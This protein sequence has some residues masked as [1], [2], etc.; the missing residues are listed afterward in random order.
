MQVGALFKHWSLRLLTPDRVLQKTY[1]AFKT[2]LAW[3]GR[4]HALMAEFE[5]LYH[6]GGREDCARTRCRQRQLT[7]AVL[8]MVDALELM[9]PGMA[10][11]L[12]AYVDKFDF[13]LRLQLAPPERFLIPPFVVDHAE[14]VDPILV[15]NKSARLV[16]LHQD[17]GVRIPDGFTITTTTFDLLLAHNNVRP[18]MDLLLAAIDLV[19]EPGLERISQALTTMVL[20]LEIPSQVEEEILAAYDGLAERMGGNPVV[21]VRSS[22]QQEDGAFSF[23]GQY[24]SALGVDRAHVLG[25][26]RQVLAS[27]Y[28]PQALRYRLHAGLCDEEAA[29]AVLVLAMVDAVASG[30]V[31]TQDPVADEEPPLLVHSVNGLGLPLVGG[32]VEPDVFVFPAGSLDPAVIRQGAQDRQLVLRGTA[33]VEE[34]CR[35]DE[36]SLTTGQAAELARIARS[37]ETLYAHPQDIEWALDGGEGV[38]ILQ[39]RPLE[40]IKGVGLNA[41]HVVLPSAPEPWGQPRVSGATPASA[42]VAVGMTCHLDGIATEALAGQRVLVTRHMTPSLVR[43]IEHL[44]AVICEQGS[45]TGHFATVCREFGVVLLVGV[46]DAL[47]QLPP[48][49]EV[50]V[51]GNHGAVYDGVASSLLQRH[52]GHAEIQIS[53]YGKRIRSMLDYIAPLHLVDPQSKEFRVQSC[54]SMHDIIRYAHEM[55]VRAMFGLGDVAGGRSS[56]SRRL[57]TD[58]PLDIYLLDVGGAFADDQSGEIALDQLRALPFLA[59]WK[60]LSHPDIDWQSHL[61][62][63]WQSF[64]DMALSGGIADGNSSQFASYAIVSVDYLN[65]NMR[66]GFHFTLIDCLCGQDS[67]AN[68]CQLR[69]AGGGGDSRGKALRVTLL[70]NILLRLGFEV[71]VQGDLLDARLSGWSRQELLSLLSDVGRLLGMTKLLDMVLREEDIDQRIEQFFQQRA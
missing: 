12:R 35:A 11:G 21:A 38:I 46:K 64:G 17:L 68:Y 24:H 50:T 43:Y 18:A 9:H 30:V 13:Y 67:R 66:F 45:V 29:M 70:H 3:D 32:E 37:I 51:D 19:D 34:P 5:A 14:P 53:G 20:H 44:A 31:Y 4:C 2:L 22:A 48:G 59:L 52:H 25:A 63:D 15:G 7:E 41:D 57:A 10:G 36:P 61:H 69:F 6:G 23:A 42:G 28:S 60:G 47:N 27:K 54:R 39:A 26:Y 49:L 62:F 40:R 8:G 56:R 65:L 71:L 16:R 55:A 1:D 33:V 58:I